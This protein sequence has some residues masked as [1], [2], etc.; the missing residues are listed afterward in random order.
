M[1]DTTDIIRGLSVF[2]AVVEAAAVTRRLT[3][4][5]SSTT[6]QLSRLGGKENTMM[7]HC[8]TSWVLREVIHLSMRLDCLPG[9]Y[10]FVVEVN[11]EPEVFILREVFWPT[12]RHMDVRRI[13]PS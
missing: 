10:L 8:S 1:L 4:S 13:N 7:S 9:C 12:S 5:R 3:D 2:A 11:V 6:A